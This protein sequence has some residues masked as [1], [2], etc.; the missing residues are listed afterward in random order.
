[1]CDECFRELG[2][3]MQ[4]EATEAAGMQDGSLSAA[5]ALAALGVG[6]FRSYRVTDE[7]EEADRL[8]AQ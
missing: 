5:L 8:A 4:A 7:R 3:A 2:E 6:A 1:A